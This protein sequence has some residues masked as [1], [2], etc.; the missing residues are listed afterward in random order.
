MKSKDGIGLD[1]TCNKEYCL[2]AGKCDGRRC[3][4]A[5]ER[6]YQVCKAQKKDLR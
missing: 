2:C 5:A 3:E 6:K 1:L 4:E